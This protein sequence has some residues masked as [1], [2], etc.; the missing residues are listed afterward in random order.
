VVLLIDNYD[1]FSYILFQYL[2]EISDILVIQNDE[3]LPASYLSRISSVVLSPGPGLPQTSG[4]LIEYTNYFLGKLP[5]LGVCLGHQTIAQ[6]A[7]AELIQTKE[8]FHGRTSQVMHQG[9]GIFRNI[10]SPFVANRYHSWA[11]SSNKLP[12]ELEVLAESEDGVI[13]GFRHRKY[14]NTYGVQFHPE[15]ILTEHGKTLLSNFCKGF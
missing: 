12:K 7:G 13:M 4:R 10:P 15:S 6:I 2:K 8:I 1:S 5:V 9:I 3:P 14:K 11:V